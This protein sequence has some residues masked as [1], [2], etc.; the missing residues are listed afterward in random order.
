MFVT[1][2]AI[3]KHTYILQ[4]LIFERYFFNRPLIDNT[5]TLRLLYHV[6]IIEHAHCYCNKMLKC[7]CMFTLLLY[8]HTHTHIDCNYMCT[9][10]HSPVSKF[11]D[12]YRNNIPT[13]LFLFFSFFFV[14]MVM[15]LLVNHIVNCSRVHRLVFSVCILIYVLAHNIFVH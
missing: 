8:T 5:Q 9:C 4:W 3:A 13:L 7:M 1:C 15:G 2:P 10:T 12:F 11:S 6:P 14:F